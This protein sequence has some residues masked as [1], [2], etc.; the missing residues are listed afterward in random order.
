MVS[1]GGDGARLDRDSSPLPKGDHNDSR[2]AKVKSTT[3]AVTNKGALTIK[4]KT[5]NGTMYSE[6]K[7]K[8]SKESGLSTSASAKDSDA[9]AETLR[10]LISLS[11]AEAANGVSQSFPCP[12]ET[13]NDPRSAGSKSVVKQQ[14]QRNQQNNSLDV[15]SAARG[16][17]AKSVDKDTSEDDSREAGLV[18]RKACVTLERNNIT[19]TTAGSTN[20]QTDQVEA[21]AGFL[22]QAKVSLGKNSSPGSAKPRGRPQTKQDGLARSSRG[23]RGRA[24]SSGNTSP[25]SRPEQTESVAVETE[26]KVIVE[27]DL[28]SPKIQEKVQSVI[29]YQTPER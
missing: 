3:T 18:L 1:G 9:P 27:I 11:P 24:S 6:V 5:Q 17:E 29:W 15:T 13:E 25:V 7:E 21:S 28:S 2:C 23:S 8:R 19:T 14:D 16:E 12:E 4:I 26:K 10:E 22:P 20:M